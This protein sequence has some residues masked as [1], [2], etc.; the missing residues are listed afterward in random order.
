M[1]K[2]SKRTD[3]YWICDVC[4]KAKGLKPFKSAYTVIGGICGWCDREDEAMLTPLRDLKN[5]SGR[6]G[7]VILEER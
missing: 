1:T 4:A 2:K 3:R 6:T 7:Y 5:E